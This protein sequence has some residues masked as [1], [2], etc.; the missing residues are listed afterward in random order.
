MI[1][2]NQIFSRAPYLALMFC[3]I[4]VGCNPDSSG[5]KE[6]QQLDNDEDPTAIERPR[7]QDP[8]LTE[9]Q[10]TMD[11]QG[12]FVV[13][14]NFDETDWPKFSQDFNLGKVENSTMTTIN[15]RTI[16]ADS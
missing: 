3:F 1:V 15:S 13:I 12:E 14:Q 16:G 2:S 9:S 8:L 5:A 10:G 11:D 4:I 7:S 6:T